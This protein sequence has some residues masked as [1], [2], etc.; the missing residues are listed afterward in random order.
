MRITVRIFAQ[1]KY[2][3]ELRLLKKRKY[4][5]FLTKIITDF[6]DQ[7][8]SKTAPNNSDV[9]NMFLLFRPSR[10]MVNL[11]QGDPIDPGEEGLA[12]HVLGQLGEELG[13]QHEVGLLQQ[14]LLVQ[15]EQAEGSSEE[16]IFAVPESKTQCENK[17]YFAKLNIFPTL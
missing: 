15:A 3:L 17:E 2:C 10:S 12:V 1:I 6:N 8:I 9:E 13:E 7:Q 5:F 14:L 4:E 11:A 16:E